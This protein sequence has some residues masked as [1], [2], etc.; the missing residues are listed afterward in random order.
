MTASPRAV[1][2]DANPVTRLGIRRA[3]EH[4]GIAV[5]GEATDGANALRV[6]MASGPDVCLLDIHIPGGGIAAAGEIAAQAPQTSVVMLSEPGSGHELLAALR[7]GANGCLFKDVGPV[8]LG[9]AVC[10]TLDG[11][12]SLPRVLIARVIDEWRYRRG[13]RRARTAEGAW[14]TLSGRESEVLE[15]MHRKLTTRQIAERLGISTVTVRRHVSDTVRRLGVRDR[16]AALRLTRGGRAI[17]AAPR[18][19]HARS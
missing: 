19:L 7:A 6:V 9:R 17:G 14:V 10:A 5:V 4:A 1:L 11:E 3:L 8:A 12:V 13:E 18:D 2:A 15:L 16:D